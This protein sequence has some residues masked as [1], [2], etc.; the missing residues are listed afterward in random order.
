MN[1]D[2]RRTPRYDSQMAI[3]VMASLGMA[4]VTN[5]IDVVF[6]RMQVDEMYDPKYRRNYSSFYEGLVRVMNEGALYRGVFA[7]AARY[8]SILGGISLTYDYVKEN[9]YYFWGPIELIR[10]L[11]VFSASFVGTLI[12]M[13]FETA[14]VR[15]QT[16]RALPNGVMPYL[17]TVDCINKIYRYE[18]NFLHNSNGG[19]FY[20]GCYAYFA[21]LF[22]ISYMSLHILDHYHLDNRV[23]ELWGSARYSFR[24]GIV[25]DVHE[26]F[27]MSA[28]KRIAYNIAGKDTEFGEVT[29][30]TNKPL[31]LV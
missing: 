31:Q 23:E 21:R 27:T 5:P 25:F 24:S 18:A 6:T 1:S 28:H 14:R 10:I 12:A 3:G 20:A 8:A 17:N 2:P 4:A 9:L 7:N 29:S 22:L 30:P 26:P 15:L 13:P 19:V 11:G 16:M